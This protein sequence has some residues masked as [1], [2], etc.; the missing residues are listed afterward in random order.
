MWWWCYMK[1]WKDHQSYYDPFT[2]ESV[3]LL[4]A[5][6]QVRGIHPLSSIN[7]C[8]Q[9]HDNQSIVGNQH[10]LILGRQVPKP[11][12]GPSHPVQ[13]HKIYVT[14][15]KMGHKSYLV[16]LGKDWRHL[17]LNSSLQLLSTLTSTPLGT[18]LLSKL[19]HI[20]HCVFISNQT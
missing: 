20:V 14:L 4:L 18:L 10:V 19:G 17:V 13:T 5:P 11:C 6:E 1:K 7:V 9:C 16:G 8:T 3:N 2:K 15:F 12:H